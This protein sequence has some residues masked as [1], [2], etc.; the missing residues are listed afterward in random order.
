MR[1]FDFAPL[2]RSTIGFDHLTALFE[3]ANK[4]ENQPSYPPY[5]IELTGTDQ[6]KIT[7]ALA[8]F[9]ENEIKIQSEQLTLS[10]VG[11]K[12]TNTD[13]KNFLH[14]GI[15][16]RNFERR[17]KLADHVEVTGAELVNGL[18]HIDLVRIIPEAMR[19]KTI[20]ITSTKPTLY[21]A[22]T[23]QSAAS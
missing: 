22:N 7:M 11:E 21:S 13:N 1:T 8:G 4:N 17:F 9:K 18:L 12:E 6:Y 5:N 2:Y 23:A 14:Q 10:V 3:N 16:A 20:K 15:A 19:P